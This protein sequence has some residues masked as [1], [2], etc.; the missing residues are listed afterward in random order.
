MATSGRNRRNF[1]AA[2]ICMCVAAG[3]VM[4]DMMLDVGVGRGEGGGGGKVNTTLQSRPKVDLALL[5]TYYSCAWCKKNKFQSLFRVVQ[6]YPDIAVPSGSE[7]LRTFERD[8][9]LL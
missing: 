9:T 4:K 8:C 5:P 3:E 6:W 2:R 7:S 1:E